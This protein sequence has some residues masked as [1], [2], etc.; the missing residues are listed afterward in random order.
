M[1][2]VDLKNTD[3]EVLLHP[4]QELE[5]TRLSTRCEAG[6]KWCYMKI[7]FSKTRIHVT[8][9]CLI[10]KAILTPGNYS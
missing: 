8:I 2:P 10:L 3:E 9:G 7:K 6:D 5:G 1:C 4:Y